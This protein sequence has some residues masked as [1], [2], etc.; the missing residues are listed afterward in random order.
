MVAGNWFAPVHAVYLS[1]VQATI[2]SNQ[3][4]IVIRVFE[5]DLRDALRN[6]FKTVID[7]SS[8]E[9]ETQVKT[10]LDEHFICKGDAQIEMI[11]ID[12]ELIGDS[13]RVVMTGTHNEVRSFEVTANYFFELFP[14]QQNVIHLQKGDMK[15]YFIFKKG[16]ES[17]TFTLSD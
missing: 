11:L 5:D 13:Y 4:E 3:T 2:G 8:V 15:K 17:F 16:K 9:F 14:T 10:Y 6:R 7:T 12:L 1:T